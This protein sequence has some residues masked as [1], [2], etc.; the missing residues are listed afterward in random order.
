MRV[1]IEPERKTTIRQGDRSGILSSRRTRALCKASFIV[2][3]DRRAWEDVGT[4]KGRSRN[5]A[6]D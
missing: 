2:G 1:Q 4:W 3:A 5:E 6:K